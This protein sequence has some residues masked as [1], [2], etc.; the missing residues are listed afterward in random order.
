MGES[1]SQRLGEGANFCRSGGRGHSFLHSQKQAGQKNP[2]QRRVSNMLIDNNF[3]GWWKNMPLRWKFPHGMVVSLH[4]NRKGRNKLNKK[5]AQYENNES[6]RTGN[7]GSGAERHT[8]TG[9]A[10]RWR[11]PWRRWRQ[12]FVER[13]PLVEQQPQQF[14]VQPQ[15]LQWLVVEP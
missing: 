5:G 1:K 14:V 15:Q 8:C 4:R 12:P 7:D 11:Q 10:W 13:K 9:T 2:S 6:N 3:C